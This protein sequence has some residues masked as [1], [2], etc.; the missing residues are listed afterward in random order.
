MLGAAVER[1]RAFAAS[2]DGSL[3]DDQTWNYRHLRISMVNWGLGL[4]SVVFTF[5]NPQHQDQALYA[6]ATIVVSV[7]AAIPRLPRR[8]REAFVSLAFVL[9]QVYLLRFVGNFTLAPLTIVLLTFY[10]D[11]APIVLS[12][13]INIGLVLL[14]WF[15]AAYFNGSTGFRVE[16]PHTGMTLRV[17]AILGDAVLALAI[18]RSGT[19][20]SRDQLTAGCRARGPSV[21]STTNSRAPGVRRYGSVTS[22]TSVMSSTISARRP[23]TGCCSSWERASTA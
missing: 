15:D 9:E 10:Q 19:Q 8:W 12:C 2:A 5:T 14:S 20:A 7:L 1:I 18:W 4:F 6:A 11:W 13:A 16:I 3:L 22:T 21:R 17:A 23:V